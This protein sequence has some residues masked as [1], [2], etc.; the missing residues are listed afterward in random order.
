VLK[1]ILAG[2]TAGH[3]IAAV[4]AGRAPPRATAAAYGDWLAGWFA[5]DAARLRQFYRE[6]GAAGFA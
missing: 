3:L 6:L 1:A 4:L 5:T 2:V